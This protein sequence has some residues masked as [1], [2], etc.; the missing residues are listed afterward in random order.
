MRESDFQVFQVN[1]LN[2]E[3]EANTFEDSPQVNR[4]SE[5]VFE[6]A[7]VDE[8]SFIDEQKF[9]SLIQGLEV[10]EEEDD[11][12][13]YRNSDGTVF[14]QRKLQRETQDQDQNENEIEEVDQQLE[15][16]TAA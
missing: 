2:Q 3:K 16:E 7:T 4:D 15:N 10:I 14:K 1:T 5:V 13:T 11:T 12:I 9:R 6:K 8:K